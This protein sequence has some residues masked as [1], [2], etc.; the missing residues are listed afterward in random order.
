MK[1]NA[2]LEYF[3]KAYIRLSSFMCHL[4]YNNLNQC[5]YKIVFATVIDNDAVS[6][7]TSFIPR[8]L[9]K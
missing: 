7:R 4:T 5:L 9:T 3:K 2:V 8:N 6:L 1:Y